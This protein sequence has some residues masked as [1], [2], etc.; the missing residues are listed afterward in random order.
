VKVRDAAT[1]RELFSC[2]GHTSSVQCVV[3]SPDGNRFI[4]ASRDKTIKLWDAQTG[5]NLM[6]FTGHTGTVASVAFSPDGARI[7]S[8]TSLPGSYSLEA[9]QNERAEVIVWDA[10]TGQ[11]LFALQGHR[12]FVNSVAYS[13]DGKRLATLSRDN[14]VKVWDAQTGQE[15]LTLTAGAIGSGCVVFSPDSKRLASS[16]K[17][18]GDIIAP[19]GAGEVKVWDAQTGEEL[20]TFKGHTSHISSI[21][22][23]PDGK[24]VASADWWNNLVKV[25]DSYTGEELLKLKKP[26]GRTVDSLAF[27]PDGRHLACNGIDGMVAVWDAT[28]LPE[29]P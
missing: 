20:L 27:S 18:S 28:P 14:T 21:V 10:Q 4:S 6:T 22:F 1:G 2:Q 19:P 23:S 26:I 5:Q 7:A 16:N 3:F 11:Q 24:R 12:R 15:L 25:W 13:P 17:L 8:S 9:G 29:K